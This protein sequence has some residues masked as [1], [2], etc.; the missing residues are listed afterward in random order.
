MVIP[1]P[2]PDPQNCRHPEM[3]AIKGSF[4][5]TE[6]WECDEWMCRRCGAT[7]SLEDWDGK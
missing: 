1:E 4:V 3:I 5:I 7:M 2:I 6:V